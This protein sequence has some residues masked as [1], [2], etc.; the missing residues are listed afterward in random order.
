MDVPGR[1]GRLRRWAGWKGTGSLGLSGAELSGVEKIYRGGGKCRVSGS[2]GALLCSP[3][4]V[5]RGSCEADLGWSEDPKPNIV[6]PSFLV[7][8]PLWRE[9]SEDKAGGPKLPP[10]QLLPG[11][12]FQHLSSQA[13]GGSTVART[14]HRATVVVPVSSKMRNSKGD[15]SDGGEKPGH[16]S[17]APFLRFCPLRIRYCFSRTRKKDFYL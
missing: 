6:P 1:E 10:L 12:E 3:H 7:A 5:G 4:P 11:S 9:G 14:C 8:V 17:S 2:W 15:L 16:P 13:R